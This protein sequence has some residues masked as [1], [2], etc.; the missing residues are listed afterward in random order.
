MAQNVPNVEHAKLNLQDNRN[1]S[2]VLRSKPPYRACKSLLLS[3]HI[4]EF[5]STSAD[6]KALR[7]PRVHMQNHKEVLAFSLSVKGVAN[8]VHA[9][10]Q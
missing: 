4:A 1:L 2:P 9:N 8:A 3:E 5:A 6:A 7:T 10:V